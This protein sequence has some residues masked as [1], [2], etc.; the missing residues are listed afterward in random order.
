VGH[1]PIGIAHTQDGKYTYVNG[2]HGSHTYKIDNETNEVVGST[3]SGVAGPYGICGN[4]DETRFFI[5]G[6]GE[7]S[8][9]KGGDLGI[10]DTGR[11]RQARDLHHMPLTLGGSASSVDHCILHP[12]P[13]VNEIWVS[14]MNGWETIVVNLDTYTPTDYIATPNGGN[15]HSGAFVR[16][17]ASWNGTLESDMGGPKSVAMQSTILAMAAAAE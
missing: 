4:W 3:S 8:H 9:N 1:H 5:V 14:N 17:D 16:Y 7:G 2:G 11:F 6:K 10:I 12:D 15:T 13:D